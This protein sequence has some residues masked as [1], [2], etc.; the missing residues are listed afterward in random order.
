MAST[1][2]RSKQSDARSQKRW[3]RPGQ[4]ELRYVMMG[5]VLSQ[6]QAFMSQCKSLTPTI[7]FE[8][9]SPTAKL[10][11]QVPQEV[12]E[13]VLEEVPEQVLEEVPEQGPEE[14]QIQERRRF[15]SGALEEVPEHGKP[16]EPYP[17]FCD[18]VCTYFF[19]NQMTS[20]RTECGD[21]GGLPGSLWTT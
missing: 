16:L 7:A 10:S 11:G 1:L 9:L 17:H 19:G 2:L 21:V 5:Y 12:L 13:Q 14:V 15:R 8:D 6:A 3:G 4:L 18:I 20:R